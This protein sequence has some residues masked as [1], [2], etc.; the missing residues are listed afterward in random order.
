VTGPS[1]AGK[2]S[3]LRALAALR[4]P[5]AGTLR[6]DGR[7]PADHGYPAYRRQ[8]LYVAQESA[9]CDESVRAA[10]ARPFSYRS[11]T[12]AFDAD[13]AIALLGRLGVDA[14]VLDR[15]ARTLSVGERQR[16]AVVRALLIGPRVLLLDEPTSA[17]DEDARDAALELI[18]TW[19]SERGAAWVV[20]TH[21]PSQIER[22]GA[23]RV[24]LEPW[25]VARGSGRAS[26]PNA[27]PGASEAAPDEPTGG[28][29]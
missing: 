11:A 6:L 16:V 5:A 8:V 1:G 19:A 9:V 26:A 29:A 18:E 25:R 12:G 15:R 28:A 20:V 22:V 2:S 24:D 14:A 4:E 7:A 27:S 13:A 17:L 10:L 3:L 23:R 21:D